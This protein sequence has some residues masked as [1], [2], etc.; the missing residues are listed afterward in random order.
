MKSNK[1]L[2]IIAIILLNV[3]VVYTIGQSFMGK[4]SEYDIALREARTYAEGNLFGKSIVSYKDAKFLS[5]S[6]ELR[7]EMLDVYDKGLESGEFDSPHEIYSEV[8]NTVSEFPKEAAIYEKAC[9]IFIKYGNYQKCAE[10]LMQAHDLSVTS[11]KIEEA[12]SLVRYQYNKFFGMYTD[13]L[14]QNDGMYT[15]MSDE[16]YCF[17]DNE[18]APDLEGA[19]TFASS[20]SEGY[21]FVRST[22]TEGNP[23]SFIIDKEGQ[24]QVYMNEVESS[25]GVGMAKDSEG[26]SVL[27]LSCKVG[28]KYKYYGIDG[29]EVFGD[30]IFAGRFRNNIAAV[31][32]KEG[33]WK[34]IDGT[35]KVITKKTFT[36]V[37][38]NELDECAP[39]GLIFAKDG[40]KYHLYNHKAEQIGDLSCDGAKAFVDDYAAI[41]SGDVWGY[42]DAEGKTVI[43]PQYE[44]AKSFSNK[45]AGVMV[46]GV[47]QFISPDNQVVIDDVYEDVGYLSN[48]GIVFVK[49]EGNWSYLKMYYTEG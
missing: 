26:E 43:E 9:D 15:A 42:V 1:I 20:F 31:M 24:R 17:L 2:I 25:S 48:E 32:E 40:E 34:L 23:I 37:V 38:L 35:G 12:R 6:A 39:K 45:M 16:A 29:K 30:Y 8:T 46:G 21:A 3:L 7:L 14:P 18:A 10:I 33:E 28:D 49:N 19:Y 13:I 41:K 36:D 22:D 47:W 4:E 27:L 44:D 5:D 11:D